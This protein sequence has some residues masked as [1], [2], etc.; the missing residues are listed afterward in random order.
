TL[1]GALGG[2]KRITAVVQSGSLPIYLGVIVLTSLAL[3]GIFLVRGTL[4][5]SQLQLADNSW[6]LVAVGVIMVAALA[7]CT[8]QRRFSA[9]LALGAT[10]YGIAVLFLLH[11]APDLALTQLLIETLVLVLF[12]LVLRHLPKR[13]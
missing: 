12:V 1:E 2:S 4:P 6:Q 8:M 11:G 5:I 3:P 13:F 9:V 7:V 10:G